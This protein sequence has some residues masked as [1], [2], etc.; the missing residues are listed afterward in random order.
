[1]AS[2]PADDSSVLKQGYL[3]KKP[4][5]SYFGWSHRR[6]LVLY[7]DGSSFTL[8]WFVNQIDASGLKVEGFSPT[9]RPNCVLGSLL[10]TSDT[11]VELKNDQLVV[12]S[13]GRRLILRPSLPKSNERD[14]LNSWKEAIEAAV[15]QLPSAAAPSERARCGGEREAAGDA[16]AEEVRTAVEAAEEAAEP[17]ASEHSM[18][19]ADAQP[20]GLA[21]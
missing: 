11:T 2:R 19:P 8:R 13:S 4:V 18:A 14:E 1:M 9:A 6:L 15:M 5:S 3:V 21:H 10:L 20:T 16:A 12:S 17:G 7:K